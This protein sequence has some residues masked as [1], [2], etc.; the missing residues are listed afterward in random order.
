MTC[1][2]IIIIDHDCCWRRCSGGQTCQGQFHVNVANIPFIANND[3]ILIDL[4]NDNDEVEESVVSTACAAGITVKVKQK[5]LEENPQPL[6]QAIIPVKLEALQP[7]HT[8]STGGEDLY[9]LLHHILSPK[10]HRSQTLTSPI[11]LFFQ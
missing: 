6:G 8:L 11:F 5:I 4:C 3:N 2:I 9:P 7:E 10:H 1:P